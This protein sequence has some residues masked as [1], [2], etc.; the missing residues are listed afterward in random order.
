MK[1]LLSFLLAVLIS[2]QCFAQNVADSDLSNRTDTNSS[3]Y[4]QGWLRSI[5]IA[6]IIVLI[7]VFGNKRHKKNV[8]QR[9]KDLKRM[10]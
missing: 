8:A 1:S 6:L 5:I 9:E 4:G 2:I 10:E 7:G 3:W